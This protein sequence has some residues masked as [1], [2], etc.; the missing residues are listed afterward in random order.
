MFMQNCVDMA[1]WVCSA[2]NQHKKCVYPSVCTLKPRKTKRQTIVSGLF[3]STNFPL[4][5]ELLELTLNC[6]DFG[7]LAD[8][9]KFAFMD[10]KYGSVSRSFVELYFD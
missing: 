2:S 9:S 6:S 10:R 7:E 3:T 5:M 4:E 1:E 8:S